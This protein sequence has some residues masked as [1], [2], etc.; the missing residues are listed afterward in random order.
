M[1]KFDLFYYA[2]RAREERQLAE[3]AKHPRACSAHRSLEKQ[4]S[5]RAMQLVLADTGKGF[6]R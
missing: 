3:T 6:N 5:L 2:K 1:P 4:Y